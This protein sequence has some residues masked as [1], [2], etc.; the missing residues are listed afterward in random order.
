MR[1]NISCF[2]KCNIH[3]ARLKTPAKH[4]S[5]FRFFFVS[6]CFVVACRRRFVCIATRC[7]FQ[8]LRLYKIL[9]WSVIGP[10]KIE[11]V[12]AVFCM[13]ISCAKG[14][15]NLPPE[16]IWILKESLIHGFSRLDK[17]ILTSQSKYLEQVHGMLIENVRSLC[18]NRFIYFQKR[19]K[20]K[21][22]WL[23]QPTSPKVN[24]LCMKLTVSST[25]AIF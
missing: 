2:V 10:N 8:F 25:F 15:T 4:V 24:S 18:G 7:F 22:N 6:A 14:E 12:I 3:T 20:Q 17:M 16:W 13:Q 23:Q 11:R 9:A 5:R 19:A 21:L 1:S